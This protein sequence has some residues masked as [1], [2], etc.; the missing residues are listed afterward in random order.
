VEI[1]LLSG[2][3]TVTTVSGQ[4]ITMST[5]GEIITVSST[6]NVS[7]PPPS[8]QPFVNFADLGPPTTN[9][10]VADALSAFDA[11]T[12]GVGLGAAA[13]GGGGGGG[14]GGSVTAFG[15]GGG[16]SGGTPETLSTFDI[17]TPTNFFSLSF[18]STPSTPGTTPTPVSPF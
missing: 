1:Q 17:N 5:A 8:N 3:L 15:G 14:G 12:G 9:I 6:G 4:T 10:T 2:A 7:Y 16:G 11:V 13:G 18:T